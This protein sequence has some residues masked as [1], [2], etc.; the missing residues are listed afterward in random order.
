[1]PSGRGKVVLHWFTGTKSEAK[2][3][4]ELG[5]YFSINAAMFTSERHLSMIN[6]IP[7]DRLL[8]ETDGPFT[9]VGD[10]LS[11]PSDVALVVKVLGGINNVPVDKMAEIIRSNLRALLIK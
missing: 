4:I 9:R 1:M 11:V 7:K 6:A 5:C 2:R 8:T 10:R 3:A